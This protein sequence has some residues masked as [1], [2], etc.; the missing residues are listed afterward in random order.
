MPAPNCTDRMPIRTS[1]TGE[2]RAARDESRGGHRVNLEDVQAGHSGRDARRQRRT[3]STDRHAVD[4]R[5]PQGPVD[6]H[7]RRGAR[8]L[9]VHRPPLR[10]GGGLLLPDR[11]PRRRAPA[12]RRGRR[13]AG[14]A[15]RSGAP[16]TSAP[17][18][19]RPP[20]APSASPRTPTPRSSGSG[21]WC[22]APR[23]DVVYAGTEPAAV[24]RSVR[25]R[26]DVRARAGAVGPPAPARVGRRLRRPG[27][28]HAAAAPH[29]PAVGD[30]RPVDRRRLPDHRRRRLVGAAQPRA[31][32]PSSCPRGSSTPSSASACTRSPA[33]RPAPSGCSCRTTAGSTAPTTRAGS[34]S[35]SPTG[36]PPTSASRSWSTRTSPTR[37]SSSRSTAATSATRPRPKA[38]V[39]RSRDAGE[40]WERARRGA[41]RLLLR[42][43]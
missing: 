28:P 13:R 31:S 41:A 21:S 5:D 1:Q 40:T 37:S 43:A 26:R 14:S 30:R 15:R 17:P 29:R 4:G 22:P 36:C 18:G 24:W 23:P 20:T 2:T 38:R 25:P 32:G 10:H 35:R 8:G 3:A 34:G 33:T 42:R 9:G 27:L 16:T 39:W 6:R 11:H 12:A 7:V 19:R